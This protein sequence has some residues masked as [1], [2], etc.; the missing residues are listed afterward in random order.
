MESKEKC[1][2][3]QTKST[4][5]LNERRRIIIKD[6]SQKWKHGKWSYY[7]RCINQYLFKNKS[8]KY[9]WNRWL[10]LEHWAIST[11]VSPLH[12]LCSLI[13]SISASSVLNLSCSIC[14]E[15]GTFSNSSAILDAHSWLI[16]IS[17]SL[18]SW[19]TDSPSMISL[20]QGWPCKSSQDCSG[21]SLYLVGVGG[22]SQLLHAGH[23]WSPH[24]I[25]WQE[26]FS[27]F[28]L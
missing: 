9:N 10:V 3:L 5:Q 14:S 7:F 24:H 19:S 8:N 6:R 26:C 23:W 17:P 21:M 4:L 18:H 28:N 16:V 22:E 11:S 2:C 12:A 27:T 13:S 20:S 1:I 15:F 25:H